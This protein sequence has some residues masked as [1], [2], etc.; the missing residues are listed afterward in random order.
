MLRAGEC[1]CFF[2]V[3][4]LFLLFLFCNVLMSGMAMP[5]KLKHFSAA[6]V[7]D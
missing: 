5:S 6:Y 1:S 7:L 4:L 3:L 2:F